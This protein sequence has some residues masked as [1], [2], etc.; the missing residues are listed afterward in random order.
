VFPVA[1]GMLT[2]RNE[3]T[4]TAVVLANT[5]NHLAC[6]VGG[7]LGEVKSSDACSYI[8]ARPRERERA[9][10]HRKR[11]ES[12]F[13]SAQS[14]TGKSSPLSLG[15]S[16]QMSEDCDSLC[17]VRCVKAGSLVTGAYSP[18]ADVGLHQD[19]IGSTK[20]RFTLADILGKR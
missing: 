4:M 8:Y 14:F 10:S 6:I 15:R 1:E 19:L 16:G 20:L 17:S 2:G 5:T 3:R 9:N 18:E 13:D 7:A 12:R 11:G